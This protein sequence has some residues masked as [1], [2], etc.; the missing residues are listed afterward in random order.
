[1]LL[2]LVPIIYYFLRLL[3]TSCF[4]LV[5]PMGFI[6]I[7]P[8]GNLLFVFMETLFD[9]M[10]LSPVFN[11]D[12]PYDPCCLIY[13]L[14][15]YVILLLIL[16]TSCFRM[17]WKYMLVLI[18]LMTVSFYSLVL[19]LCKI[20]VLKMAQFLMLVKPLLYH[21]RAKILVL[22]LIMNCVIIL[23]YVPIMSKILEFCWTASPIFITTWS[24]IFSRLRNIGFY[25]LYYLFLFSLLTASMFCVPPL[26]DP[27]WSMHL[28][29][30]TPLHTRISPNSKELN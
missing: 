10:L 14:M 16:S 15:I 24:H 28:L 27:I 7:W 13:L 2:T 21:L 12:L 3:T 17:I 19:I 1:M 8:I 26:C 5:M 18:M 11:K 25:S 20:G 29:P 22:T 23:F 9:R 30:G 6:A 4:P